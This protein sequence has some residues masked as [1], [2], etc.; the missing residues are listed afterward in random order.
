MADLNSILDEE[1][2]GTESDISVIKQD[3]LGA[4]STKVD[5]VFCIDVTGSMAPTIQKVKDLTLSLYDELISTMDNEYQR[6][7]DQM[8]VK[9]FAFRDYYCD[10]SSSMSESDFFILPDEKTKFH[11]FVS[12]LEAC[13]GGDEPEN[14]LEALALAM[15][16]DW[17]KVSD[18]NT[19][20]ARNVI[21]L[22]TD[23]SAHPLEK[24]AESKNCYYPDNMLANYN[25]LYE[26]WQGQGKTE[27]SMNKDAKRLIIFAPEDS[28]P[29]NDIAEEFDNT[30]VVSIKEADGGSDL[31]RST[32]IATISGSMK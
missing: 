16:T 5:I 32:I 3:A 22:F 11:D 8:R 26:A 13:G 17:V 29:W 6:R 19:E 15:K 23:A 9:V 20:K 21:V 24:A 30:A 4:I 2:T 18:P 7:V 14:S 1:K 25:E 31:D 27:Y 12:K 10:G 28:Y